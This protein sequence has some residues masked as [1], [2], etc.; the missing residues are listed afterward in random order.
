MLW[1][2]NLIGQED[3]HIGETKRASGPEPSL[4]NCQIDTVNPFVLS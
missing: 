1:F 3:D 4:N 2:S